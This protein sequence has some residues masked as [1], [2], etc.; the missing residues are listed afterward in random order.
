[1]VGSVLI[2]DFASREALNEW[3]ISDPYVAS[4]VWREVEVHPFRAAVRTWLCGS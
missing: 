1:M 2:V 4:G 3:L